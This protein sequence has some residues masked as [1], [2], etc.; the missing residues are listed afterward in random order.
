MVR[1]AHS[2]IFIISEYVNKC[3]TWVDK[4]KIKSIEN[5][6]DVFNH[7]AVYF[8]RQAFPE[9]EIATQVKMLAK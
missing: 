4:E 2:S 1:K 9:Q 6:H 8:H 7:E 5:V 3:L